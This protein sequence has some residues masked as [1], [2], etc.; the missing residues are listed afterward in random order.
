MSSDL[1]KNRAKKLPDAPDVAAIEKNDAALK[2]KVSNTLHAEAC[3]RGES[4]YF[5]PE[6]GLWV[7]TQVAHL[8][9]GYCCGNGCRHC[10]YQKS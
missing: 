3:A 7:T 5:D 4:L 9:R 6:V 10:P 8:S 1:P 2:Q